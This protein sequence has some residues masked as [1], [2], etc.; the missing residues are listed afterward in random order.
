M[1]RRCRAAVP[2]RHRR[3]GIAGGG[4]EVFEACPAAVG[5]A[6]QRGDSC[7]PG[8]S[9]S[10]SHGRGSTVVAGAARAQAKC[11]Q[12]EVA[13]PRFARGQAVSWHREP[14]KPAEQA[15]V[16][17][18][19]PSGRGYGQIAFVAA[20]SVHSTRVP[21]NALEGRSPGPYDVVLRTHLANLKDVRTASIGHSSPMRPAAHERPKRRRPQ[22]GKRP[23]HTKRAAV[24]RETLRRSARASVTLT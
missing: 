2:D 21:V 12:G 13:R 5:N 14:G 11:M 3:I 19:I 23:A 15:V 20:T 22:S 4:G 16:A 7:E 10:T 17:E 24:E 9:F 1:I 18:D 6:S 8:D